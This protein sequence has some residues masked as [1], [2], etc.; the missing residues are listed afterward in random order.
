M[1]HPNCYLNETKTENKC[2]S[3]FLAIDLDY[4]NFQL[5]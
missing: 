5:S 1:Q 2:G 4:D 3:N